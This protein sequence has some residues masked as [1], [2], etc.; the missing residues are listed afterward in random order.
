MSRIALPA[1]ERSVQPWKNGGGRTI[2]IDVSPPA[3][4]LGDF[5]WRI[6]TAS[7]AVPGRFSHFDGVDRTLAVIEGRLELAI[8]GR[9]ES[10]ELSA[11]SRPHT[12]AGDIACVGTP[13]DGDVIDLNVMVRRGRW[14]GTIERFAP[15]KTVSLVLTSPCA[16]ILFI[17]GGQLGWRT[18]RVSL[19]PWDAI[20][21]DDSE[22]E[23]I[24]LE[25]E[26]AVYVIKLAP[27]TA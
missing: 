21:I 23:S 5:D 19:R 4:G 6:S 26:G 20:R 17:A 22:G 12:F 27:L 2:E 10:I 18:D 11:A 25:S 15:P 1:A 3:A 7:V 24:A 9:V 8:D 14:T 16:I 13:I